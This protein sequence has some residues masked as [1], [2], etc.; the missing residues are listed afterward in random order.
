MPCAGVATPHLSQN[1]VQI[2]TGATDYDFVCEWSQ[3]VRELPYSYSPT[4]LQR[5]KTGQNSAKTPQNYFKISRRTTAHAQRA[6]RHGG[7]D[8]QPHDP[9]AE[10][11]ASP[12]APRLAARPRRAQTR[13]ARRG[14][15]VASPSS[16]RERPIAR[17]SRVVARD[18]R[19][20]GTA[21]RRGTVP[22][23]ARRERRGGARDHL[24]RERGHEQASIGAGLRDRQRMPQLPGARV[25]RLR[26]LPVR[27]PRAARAAERRAVAAALRRAERDPRGGGDVRPHGRARARRA[28]QK[29]RVRVGP[30]GARGRAVNNDDDRSAADGDGDGDAGAGAVAPP[31]S[32]HAAARGGRR[33]D[34]ARGQR[35]AAPR[36]GAAH[37]R[38]LQI[39]VGRVLLLRG[40]GIGREE[41][42][43]E[44]GGLP[45][46]VEARGSAREARRAA[47]A[48]LAA[49]SR[50]GRDDGSPDRHRV[51]PRDDWLGQ[52]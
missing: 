18:G 9:I 22:A 24:G 21:A 38:R 8:V 7:V 16:R 27:A 30:R 39:E 5:A 17:T 41:R 47:L 28:A 15:P 23:R 25:R 42:G 33:E 45:A 11:D 34:S 26:A 4:V 37:E 19:G 6:A 1:T 31:Q 52:A 35:G 14:R 51:R 48:A 36:A 2:A 43:R 29:A 46:H 49:A 13:R 40:G 50:R 20:R 3:R 44:R 10:H 32:V 12:R